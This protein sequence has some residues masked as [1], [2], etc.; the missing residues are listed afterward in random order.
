[1]HKDSSKNDAN[2]KRLSIFSVHVH[3]DGSRIAT[4]GL[5]AKIRI[6]STKPI[7]NP[8]SEESGKPPKSL[9]TLSMH[10]GPV[11]VVRW[12]HNGRWLASGS[13]DEI[14]MIWD[15]DPHGGGKVWGSDEVN[16]EGWKPLKRLPGHDSD[17]TDVAWSPQDRYLASVGLDS[18]VII[19]DGYTLECVRKLEQ[20][21]GFVKG[22]CW[23]PVGEFLATQS[24]D[25]TVKI[26]RTRD[27]SLEAEVT[28]P[29]EDSPGSTF[30]R[31][32]SWSPDGAHITASNATNNKGFVFIAAVITRNVWTSEI[33]LVGHENTVEV[34]CYNPHIF[35]RDPSKPVSTSNI[36]SVVALGAD[37]RSVSVWQTKSARPLIVAKQVFDRQI[38]DL[39]WS[40]DGLTL[41]AAS[42][43]GTIAVLGFTP[44]ELE[45]I[46]PHSVQQEYLK[47]FDFSLPPP[48]PGYDHVDANEA[49]AATPMPAPQTMDVPKTI[50]GGEQ[51]NQ[52]VARRGKPK[53]RAALIPS[54]STSGLAQNPG[55]ISAPVS[56]RAMLSQVPDSR[57]FSS[58]AKISDFGGDHGFGSPFDQAFEAPRSWAS[59]PAGDVGAPMDIDVPIDALDGNGK[60]GKRAIIDLTE[61]DGKPR[62]RTLGGDRKVEAPGM[63]KAL[64]GWGE[65]ATGEPS[66]QQV[67]SATLIQSPPL[68]SYL[69]TEAEEMECLLEAKNNDS[70]R[71]VEVAFIVGKQVQWLDYVPSPV[72]TLKA[73]ASFC[74]AAMQDGCLNVYSH[75]GRRNV[76]QQK[77][78]FAP[79]SLAPVLSSSPNH[80]VISATV[81]QTGAPIIHISNSVIYSYDANL[82]SFV[83]VT[84]RWWAEHSD[85]W[86]GRAR[87]PQAGSQG[88]VT[89]AERALNGSGHGTPAPDHTPKPAWWETAI[90]LGHL[91]TRLHAMKL[92]ADSGAEYRH[93]VLVYAKRLADEGFRGKAEELIKEL[94]GP[95]YWR[96]G[97]EDATVSPTICGVPRRDLLKDVLGIFVRSKTLTKLGQDWQETLKRA[98]SEDAL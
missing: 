45:G 70:D 17:V 25:R 57:T 60:K 90:T 47:K 96:P 14:V 68:L 98:N 73:T 27:W 32:L 33:S 63:A 58:S 83:K 44:E 10:T 3:P 84:E 26:W 56:K 36:C 34:A 81:S 2:A 28:K 15:L 51:V 89:Q 42:S 30:F 38:M 54:A 5:D 88:A 77:A 13:D 29:F 55:S 19:W 76:K 24:D 23:D 12:A 92:F 18:K 40:W 4:G 53:K 48:P 78:L 43:D 85:A 74:A 62:G 22:V 21:Q 75:T 97:K 9:C 8:A 66:R 91:E 94:Y 35:L 46:A 65:G 52:L 72:I 82:L 95:V 16:V 61:E 80:V 1:M 69:S 37:D 6:W 64:S 11:L 20:H 71:T 67:Y 7:L 59:R 39:S 79:T 50:V 86:Q 93:V 49:A 87:A 41:Y 31:R